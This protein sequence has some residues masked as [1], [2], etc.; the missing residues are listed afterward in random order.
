M[1]K[2]VTTYIILWA[3]AALLQ[4]ATTT[5]WNPAANP[6]GTGRW[7]EKANWTGT[8][9]NGGP[10][11][12]YKCVFNVNGAREC[13]I[14]AAITVSQVVQGDNGPGG[15]VRIVNGGNLTAGSI[16]SGGTNWTGV[17]YNR[18][19]VMSVEA[20]GVLTCPDDLWVGLISPAVGT[21]II[22]GGSVHVNGMFGAGWNSTGIGY[23]K[24]NAGLLNLNGWHDS[25]SIGTGSNVDIAGGI[26]HISGDKTTSILAMIADKRI[27]AY[28]GRGKV[29]YDYN[30]TI[31]GKTTLTALPPV[32]GD[33][34][35][36]FGV[37]IADLAILADSWLDYNCDGIANLDTLCRVDLGD[38]N[39]L[40][41]NWLSGMVT[42]WH[43]AQTEFPT[44][45]WIVTPYY[46][47]NWGIV[48]DGQTDVTEAIQNAMVALSNSGGGTLFLPSGKYKVSGNLT[49]PSRVILRGD[50]Q[51]PNPPTP[52]QG[53]S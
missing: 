2:T 17:G 25:Q 4:A 1:N 24:V 39:V 52:L 53:R 21:L 38:F 14:D 7:T 16:P 41:A 50:W 42:D 3:G 31:P 30:I 12:D 6:S 49:V 19:A 36:D 22:D 20:G 23:V 34:N 37:D 10:Q 11:G 9:P 18:N 46:A 13:L 5:T 44:D 15:V 8:I 45:D 29:V 27:T 32:V 33:I 40:A 26:V 47:S 35:K 28:G 51:I 43:I 48:G